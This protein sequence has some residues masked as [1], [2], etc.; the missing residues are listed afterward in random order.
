LVKEEREKAVFIPGRPPCRG[1]RKKFLNPLVL[2]NSSKLP[3]ARQRDRKEISPTPAL[4]SSFKE[5]FG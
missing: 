4:V 5:E 1:R 2:Q 3:E